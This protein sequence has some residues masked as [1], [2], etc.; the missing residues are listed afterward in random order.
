[1][2]RKNGARNQ[3]DK[4]AGAHAIERL[5]EK[6]RIKEAYKQAKLCFHQDASPENR[7]LVERIYLLRIQE[8]VRGG[9]LD[10]GKEVARSFLEF[11]V[12]DAG[13]LP[14]FLSVLP[15]VGLAGAAVSL[16]SRL[17]SPEAQAELTVKLADLAV[18][19][20]DQTPSSRAELREG[21]QRIRAALTAVAEGNHAQASELLKDIARSSP[22]A[23]WRYF[24]RGLAAMRRG[25]SEQIG[26][27]EQ[28]GESEQA[29]ANWE[30]LDPR[31]S[32]HRIAE[33]LRRAAAGVQVA[34]AD[35]STLEASVFG[36][37]LLGRLDRL[38]GL[39]G[40]VPPKEADWRRAI[41]LLR[42]LSPA[43]RRVD[44][45]LSQRLTALLLEPLRGEMLTRNFESAERLARDFT[46]AVEPLTW[47]PQWN[48]FWA[49][50]LRRM[51][52]PTRAVACWKQY[53]DDLE[54]HP[55]LDPDERRRL[56][57]LVWRQ[58]AEIDADMVD[59]DLPFEW[60]HTR[61]DDD[62][63]PADDEFKSSA[64]AALENSLRFDPS[65][66]DS[67][68]MRI[69]LHQQWG[70]AAA[71]RAAAERLLDVF[72]DDIE[73]S[74]LLIEHHM[75]QDEPEA[76]LGYIERVQA[77]KPL[78]ESCVR[79]E[80]WAWSALARRRALEGR[81]DEGR[82][83]FARAAR[84]EDLSRDFRAVARQAALEFKAGQDD[85]AERFVGQAMALVEEPA[86]VW[87][88]LAIEGAR[89]ELPPQRLRDFQESFHAA[90]R[91]RTTGRTAALMAE[92]LLACEL[93]GVK[94]PELD[95][96]R[97]AVTAYISRA[98]RA[99]YAQADMIHVCQFLL[100][101]P[102]SAQVLRL[103][104][105]RGLRT[106]PQ[107]ATFPFLDSKLEL[108]KGPFGGG[109]ERALG[110][111]NKSLRLA[112]ASAEPADRELVE[113]IKRQLLRFDDAREMMASM[114]FGKMPFDLAG[115]FDQTDDEDLDDEDHGDSPGDDF[116]GAPYGRPSF[117]SS[118]PK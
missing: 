41:D 58:I 20:P 78:D 74:R 84:I 91:K 64:I 17:D 61:P 27:S 30:R 60:F 22:W 47:D 101:A 36:E 37:S 53:A 25:V 72:P 31:R 3:A 32:A 73:A 117:S 59:A 45:R 28:G 1:M 76:A 66:R 87:L 105:R 88:S 77:L 94:Y 69:E 83:A 14:E 79:Q 85:A 109:F 23:D 65:Q 42:S 70:Q 19:H 113:V 11:G 95:D 7:R 106:F 18:S 75:S 24:V 6:K 21:A 110:M 107:C 99:K 10:V 50:V 111:L 62:A 8:L 68:Q 44:P 13:L 57:A 102:E 71:V 49:L 48:R 90:L 33:T 54:K 100:H 26:V 104:I 56:L 80:P 98:K 35:L 55:S 34:N 12:T 81:W 82:A 93:H 96:H 52:A 86:A 97:R 16:A 116:F 118:V 15:Q 43:L 5:I 46:G 103:F 9:S 67:H 38:A 108:S 2:A 112:Q 40:L 51:D 29:L 115:M 63:R 89:Y 39:V 114:C 4:R 92:T